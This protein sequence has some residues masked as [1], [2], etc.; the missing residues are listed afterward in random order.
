MS[1]TIVTHQQNSLH[2]S[3][4]NY[5]VHYTLLK[6]RGRKLSEEH[7]QKL[8]RPMSEETKLK[9]SRSKT[10]EHNVSS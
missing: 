8:R 2:R 6:M 1:R 7:K 3:N 4:R 9:I 5:L 10:K